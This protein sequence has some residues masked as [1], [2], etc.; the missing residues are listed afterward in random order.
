M[1][2]TSSTCTRSN[3]GIRQNNKYTSKYPYQQNHQPQQNFQS[4]NVNT[5]SQ[6]VYYTMEPVPVTNPTPQQ[7]ANVTNTLPKSGMRTVTFNQFSGPGVSVSNG[8]G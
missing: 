1:G 8:Q 7:Y 4:H 3:D 5:S 6:P 2:H